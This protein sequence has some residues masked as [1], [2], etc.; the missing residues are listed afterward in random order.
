MRGDMKQMFSKIGVPLAVAA[1]LSAAA[2]SGTVAQAAG[3]ETHV[4]DIDFSF[5]GP[6]GKFD[7]LQLQRGLK[8]YAEVCAACHGLQYVAL[9]TLGDEGGPELPEDQVRAF[10]SQY[11]VF[12]PELDDDR[13]TTPSDHFPKSSLDNAPDLSLM[14]K[15][16][17]GFHG[18]YGTGINQLLKGIGGPEYIYT[19]LTSYEDPPECAPEDFDG[20]Y[21]TAFA[22]GGFPDECKDENGNHTVPGSWIAMAQPLYG[23]DLE[24]DDGHPSDIQNEAKDVAA[25]LM[26][27]AEP[28][29]MARKYAGLTGV[30]FLTVLSV[31]LYLTNKRLWA[32]IKGRKRH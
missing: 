23:D 29:L 14:A 10:S 25:F 6:F 31:L 3:A 32:P 19:L 7:T 28:K 17:A 30:L 1:C 11:E 18:P 21:N 26:W 20:Y 27:T 16:R 8:I 5:E 13:P 12:D 2:F 15:K 24:F 22:V 9:R 4:E